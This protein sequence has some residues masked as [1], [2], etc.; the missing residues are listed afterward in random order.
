MWF[1]LGYTAQ[2]FEYTVGICNIEYKYISLC[3]LIYTQKVIH[4]LPA[5]I[6]PFKGYKDIYFKLLTLSTDCH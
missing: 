6:F 3:F 1:L 5:H 4:H 2:M